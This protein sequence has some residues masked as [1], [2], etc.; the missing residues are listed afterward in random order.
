MNNWTNWGSTKPIYKPYPLPKKNKNNNRRIMRNTNIT[1]NS[2]S[3]IFIVE[4]HG[5]ISINLVIHYNHNINHYI[6][7]RKAY[8]ISHK[9]HIRSV[10]GS[11]KL[12]LSTWSN[13]TQTIANLIRIIVKY[14]NQIANNNNNNNKNNKMCMI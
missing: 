14:N 8:S 5:L 6:I 12:F 4:I 3:N 11:R 13:R 9:S 1:N 10:V 2:S 7:H